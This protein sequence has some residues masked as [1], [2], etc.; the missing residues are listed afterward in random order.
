MLTAE[1]KAVWSEAFL[2][3]MSNPGLEE[4][5]FFTDLRT[6]GAAVGLEVPGT[7]SK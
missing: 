1:E 5:A 3:K 7:L 6:N 4:E 2:E